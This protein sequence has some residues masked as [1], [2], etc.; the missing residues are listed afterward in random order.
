[1]GGEGDLFVSGCTHNC[2][3]HLHQSEQNIRKLPKNGSLEIDRLVHT[4]LNIFSWLDDT[5]MLMLFAST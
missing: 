1:M 2:F 3:K 4:R 5:H